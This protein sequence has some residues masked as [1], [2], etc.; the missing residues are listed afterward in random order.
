MTCRT[1]PHMIPELYET[2]RKRWHKALCLEPLATQAREQS[3]SPLRCMVRIVCSAFSEQRDLE[4][5]DMQTSS[6]PESKMQDQILADVQD[7]ARKMHSIGGDDIMQSNIVFLTARAHWSTGAADMPV[8]IRV[9][10]LGSPKELEFQMH[11]DDATTWHSLMIMIDQT[12]WVPAICQR[13]LMASILQVCRQHT[14][15]DGC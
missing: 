15:E 14:A 6:S 10:Q 4:A 8:Q 11:I 5:D 1:H 7:K 2:C 12:E 13:L 3:I 9:Y